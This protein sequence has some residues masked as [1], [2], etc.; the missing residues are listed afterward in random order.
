LGGLAGIVAGMSLQTELAAEKTAKKTDK[1]KSGGK[2]APQFYIF[3]LETRTLM[4]G[5]MKWNFMPFT[6]NLFP[7][8]EDFVKF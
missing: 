6:T 8:I 1:L 3:K 2:K 4:T 7:L 5:Q